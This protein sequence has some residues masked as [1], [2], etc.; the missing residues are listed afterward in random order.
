M[1]PGPLSKRVIVDRLGWVERMI[2]EI[3]A[4]PLD[5]RSAFLS[6]QRN[7]WAAESFLRRALE[8][9]FDLGRHILAA[10]FGVGARE[11]NEIARRLRE[12]G[13][14][15]EEEANLLRMLA[16]YGVRL[17]HLY[18]ETTPDELF[19]ICVDHLED[20]QRMVETYRRWLKDH[21]EWLDEES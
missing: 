15:A 8:A 17:V 1:S 7:I 6:D 3:R 14:L 20:M 13:V 9:L 11:Y 5:D 16:R 19:H 18:H 10:G 4:L 2:A 12:Q 21:A